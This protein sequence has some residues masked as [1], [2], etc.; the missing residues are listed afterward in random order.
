QNQAILKSSGR[1]LGECRMESVPSIIGTAAI[2][3]RKTDADG[4]YVEF[5]MERD[6]ALLLKKGRLNKFR[7]YASFGPLT[8][9]ATPLIEI[10][11]T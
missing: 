10:L 5:R 8:D 2:L 7:L 11:V 4:D 9:D 3:S 6:D 1:P